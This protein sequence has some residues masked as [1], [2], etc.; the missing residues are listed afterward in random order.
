MWKKMIVKKNMKQSSHYGQW[1]VRAIEM[2]SRFALIVWWY[3][4]GSKEKS[5][6]LKFQRIQLQRKEWFCP[7]NCCS[8]HLTMLITSLIYLLE[9][10]TK[11]LNGLLLRWRP[12]LVILILGVKYL[13]LNGDLTT[14]SNEATIKIGEIFQIK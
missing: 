8:M 1:K 2:S 3:W 5:W 4:Y 13:T 10:R 14:N 12:W 11:G 6:Q 7:S 9:W